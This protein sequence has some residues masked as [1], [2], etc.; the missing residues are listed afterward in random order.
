ME[1]LLNKLLFKIDEQLFSSA[2]IKQNGVVQLVVGGEIGITGLFLHSKL[3]E[4]WHRGG[5]R[6]LLEAIV[7][8]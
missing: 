5:S 6:N 7:V 8:P 2:L 4:V 3:E 1:T